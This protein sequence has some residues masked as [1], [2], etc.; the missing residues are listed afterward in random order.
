L[1]SESRA[2]L[3]NKK[4]G[5]SRG[6]KLETR[7]GNVKIQ[8]HLDNNSYQKPAN[9]TGNGRGKKCEERNL[10]PTLRS[11]GCRKMGEKTMLLAR[12]RRKKK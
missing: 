12:R 2:G 10:R 1:G 9:D 8:A 5:Y 4:L 6:G 7:K 3:R 11:R